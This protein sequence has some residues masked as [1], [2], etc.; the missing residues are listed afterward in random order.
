MKAQCIGTEFWI[1]TADLLYRLFN[2]K[3]LAEQYAW[4]VLQ[5]LTWAGTAP[6]RKPNEIEGSSRRALCGSLWAAFAA[7][8][9]GI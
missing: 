5:D 4:R 9:V 3:T 6:A 7:M 2:I 1:A 8:L